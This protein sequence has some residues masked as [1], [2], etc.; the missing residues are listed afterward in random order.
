MGSELLEALRGGGREGG[1]EGWGGRDGR[2]E[3]G[4][5]TLVSTKAKPYGSPSVIRKPQ[6]HPQEG[7]LC[8]LFDFH[9][10]CS[11]TLVNKV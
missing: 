11:N 2:R 3:R 1:R 9:A 5:Q 6:E 10:K 7:V 4:L 8:R